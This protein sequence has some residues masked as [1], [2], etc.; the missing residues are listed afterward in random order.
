[1]TSRGW[2]SSPA[3]KKPHE[4][5][6]SLIFVQGR[7][8][9]AF[10][11]HNCDSPHSK[12]SILERVLFRLVREDLRSRQDRIR[13]KNRWS[14]ES[15]LYTTEFISKCHS[16]AVRALVISEGNKAVALDSKTKPI[17]IRQLTF[18]NEPR[19]CPHLTVS[20]ES[21]KHHTWAYQ[22][23]YCTGHRATTKVESECIVFMTI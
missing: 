1:M 14:P 10:P 12:Y 23:A 18:K 8:R 7:K 20:S 2:F 13:R 19:R 9:V 21:C 5:R 17:S 11:V 15:C 16:S 4:A 22:H 6:P 3:V